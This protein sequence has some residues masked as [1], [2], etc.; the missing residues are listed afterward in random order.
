MNIKWL[1][2]SL[3]VYKIDL[4]RTREEPARRLYRVKARV[5]SK[6]SASWSKHPTISL[7]RH[8][9]RDTEAQARADWEAPE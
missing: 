2:R 9:P 6:R 7:T 8:P 5:W 4:I 3:G 1:A